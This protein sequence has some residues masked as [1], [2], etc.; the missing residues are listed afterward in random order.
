MSHT[1]GP[2]KIG[3]IHWH[4]G[5]NGADCR[6]TIYGADHKPVC[7]V[8][9]AQFQRRDD[10]SSP[11]VEDHKNSRNAEIISNAPAMLEEISRLRA[12][13][14]RLSG[15]NRKRSEELARIYSQLESALAENERL[16]SDAKLGRMVRGLGEQDALGY[17]RGA[18]IVDKFRLCD[19]MHLK[20]YQTPGEA[21]A[22]AGIGEV[23]HVD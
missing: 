21:L 19:V 16:Q 9:G 7:V 15:V 18:W 22:A 14:E 6:Q 8:F 17:V 10:L 3:P 4:K 20:G 2:W 1:P 11:P 13:V 23:E 12:E 5:C